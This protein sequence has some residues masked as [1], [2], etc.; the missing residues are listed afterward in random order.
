MN[1]ERR[2]RRRRNFKLRICRM[3]GDCW[4]NKGARSL[5]ENEKSAVILLFKIFITHSLKQGEIKKSTG[6]GTSPFFINILKCV[7]PLDLKY[8]YVS[9]FEMYL[10]QF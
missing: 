4:M 7:H 10:S 1:R 2:K 8:I 5:T 9:K 3:K 6:G